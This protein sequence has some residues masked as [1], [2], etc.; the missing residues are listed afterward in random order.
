MREETILI[1]AAEPLGNLGVITVGQDA[2]I[3]AAYFVWQEVTRPIYLVRRIAFVGGRGAV[4]SIVF[5][6]AASDLG[7]KT[8][9]EASLIRR[10]GRR[11]GE[12][13]PGG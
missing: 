12:R 6:I 9:E 3:T 10:I 2:R 7:E 8:G 4:V 11:I 1:G 13:V 5:S